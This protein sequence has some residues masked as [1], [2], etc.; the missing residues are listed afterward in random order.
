MSTRTSKN[1]STFKTIVPSLNPDGQAIV[2]DWYN[3]W[4]GTEH[5]AGPTPWLYHRRYGARA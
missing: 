2:A 5:E 4:V 3:K 1:V